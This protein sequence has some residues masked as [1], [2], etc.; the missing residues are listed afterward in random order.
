MKLINNQTKN[1]EKWKKAEQNLE[2]FYEV[3]RLVKKYPIKP[4]EKSVNSQPYQ[5]PDNFSYN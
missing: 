5:I 4:I 1:I 3:I 2:E